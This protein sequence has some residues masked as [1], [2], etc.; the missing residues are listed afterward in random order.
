VHFAPAITAEPTPPCGERPRF[1]IARAM[2]P[3][4]P[5]QPEAMANDGRSCN[6]RR[7]DRQHKAVPLRR[8]RCMRYGF[9]RSGELNVSRLRRRLCE[10]LMMRHQGASF[11]AEASDVPLLVHRCA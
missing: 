4:H 11:W 6:S 8:A 7:P 3:L 5:T 1:T 9:A 10:V 2:D